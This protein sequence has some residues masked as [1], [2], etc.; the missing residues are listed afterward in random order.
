[1]TPS[2]TVINVFSMV[3]VDGASNIRVVLSFS[4]LT[5]P[6]WWVGVGLERRGSG[7][8]CGRGGVVVG[9]G[10]TVARDQRDSRG[11]RQPFQREQPADSEDD[12]VEGR[13]ER[14]T[15]RV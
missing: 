14:R 6:P 1:M 10:Y 4:W 8:G 15:S 3:S 11:L 5:G 9:V 7:D 12:D 2:S 13:G